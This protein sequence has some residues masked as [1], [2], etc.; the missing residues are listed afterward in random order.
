M[1]TPTISVIIPTTCDA[2]REDQLCRALQSVRTQGD[3]VELIVVVN[4][5]R[6]SEY[7]YRGLCEQPV[8][9]VIRL[10]EGN[11]S[12]AR[13]AG[14]KASTGDYFCFLDDDDE[15]LPGALAHRLSLFEDGVDCVVTN[16]WVRSTDDKRLVSPEV[17]ATVND[18]PL[19]SFLV[20][21]WF[22][23]AGSMFRKDAI[24]RTAFNIDHRYFEWTILFF[25]LHSQGVRFKYDDTVT[26]RVWQN[27]PD[28]ASK[29]EAY[30]I[31]N[32]NLLGTLLKTPQPEN[33]Q[34]VLRRKFQ[35]ALNMDSQ[36][37]LARGERFN[38]WISHLY[39]LK[40]GGWR[41]LP[42]T[43]KLIF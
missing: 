25:K 5:S 6:V 42:F 7:M 30:Q 21:N 33:V 41:Y 13:Y 37:R 22:A 8:N 19:N 10:E 18:E 2:R 31:A 36:M 11:V 3:N 23:S 24:D 1:N 16:G 40:S 28:S 4:G 32:V 39:C 12:K 9:N 43:R 20:Q 38:A 17:A 34:A 15:F 26:Y 27:T 14:L 35:N 29:S